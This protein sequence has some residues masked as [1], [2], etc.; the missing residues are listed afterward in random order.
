MYDAEAGH[1]N[2]A[3]ET[4]KPPADTSNRDL[5]RIAKKKRV[6]LNLLSFELT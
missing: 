4:T 6:S 2:E 1:Y 5:G 3:I